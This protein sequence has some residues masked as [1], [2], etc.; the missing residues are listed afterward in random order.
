MSRATTIIQQPGAKESI[1]YLS[2]SEL[3]STPIAPVPPKIDVRSTGPEQ[4]ESFM[5]LL[6]FQS[7]AEA[8][9]TAA[10]IPQGFK[11]LVTKR[12]EERGILFVPIPNKYHEAK[13]VY[14][15]GTNGVQCYIDRNVIFYSQNG[16]TW[17]PTSLNRLLDVS[18]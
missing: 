6:D 7:F 1:S 17:I 2:S 15:I 8:V 5:Y 3:N 12:C 9:R 4:D 13:Q 18:C 11:D 14:R 16:S 10:K